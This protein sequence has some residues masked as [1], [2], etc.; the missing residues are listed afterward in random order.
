MTFFYG[1]HGGVIDTIQWEG[2]REG[3]DDMRYA[4]LMMRLARCAEKSG[5]PSV[6]RMGRS[7]IRLLQ[8]FK[9]DSGDMAALRLEMVERIMA[10]REKVGDM[11][12]DAP[13][14]SIAANADELIAKYMVDAPYRSD[15]NLSP[16][17]MRET[18]R[19]ALEGGC[20]DVPDAKV[21][22][23]KLDEAGC[24]A[25]WLDDENAV[26]R[27]WAMRESVA[28]PKPRRVMEVPYSEVRVTGPDS[29]KLL[30]VKP[31]G[32]IVD[33][34]YGGSLDFLKT[35]VGTGD[36]GVVAASTASAGKQ[37]KAA[38]QQISAAVPKSS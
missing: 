33:R 37:T 36:R 29:W 13:F 2:F 26:R 25:N 32:Q 12:Q 6:E 8:S 3:I 17:T 28:R 15:V 38:A 31:S 20:A 21:R 4:T 5:V 16:E 18:V 1:V 9:S 35:D 24:C 23:E 7:A 34:A 27:L 22:I 14:K 10:L 30:S 11:P 19:I